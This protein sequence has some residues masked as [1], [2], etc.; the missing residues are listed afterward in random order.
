MTLRNKC[1][2]CPEIKK[3][4][5]KIDFLLMVRKQVVLS[6]EGGRSILGWI[7]KSVFRRSL[8]RKADTDKELLYPQT[9][10]RQ[11]RLPFLHERSV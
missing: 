3:I 10:L 1:Y 6:M 7:G 11:G 5:G 4:E 8:S 9:V 2:Q